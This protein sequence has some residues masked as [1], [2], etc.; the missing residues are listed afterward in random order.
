M[1]EKRSWAIG[2]AVAIIKPTL[3]ATTKREWIAGEEN[4]PK[5][6]GS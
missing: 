2:V 6:V 4:F 5:T 1:Q 3:L